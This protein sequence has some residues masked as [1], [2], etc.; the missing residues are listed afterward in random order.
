[1]TAAN[2]VP[3][4]WLGL[5]RS[6][7]AVILGPDT[8][9]PL[10][11]TVWNLL[12]D[13]PEVHDVLHAVTSG[14]GVPLS[15]TPWFGI[16]GF[17]ESLRVFLRGDLDLTVQLPG[18]PVELDGR[19]V[20]TWTER[21]L[22]APEWFSLTVPGQSSA[23]EL[24]VTEGAVLLKSLRVEAA[25]GGSPAVKSRGTRSAQF[26]SPE[27]AV[28]LGPEASAETVAGIP[29]ET[30]AGMPGNGLDGARLEETRLP[31]TGLTVTGA[32][33]PADLP[34]EPDLPGEVEG[35]RVPAPATELTGSYDHLWDKTV[36]R[37]IEDA[38]V[39]ED[40]EDGEDD[41]GAPPA[42]GQETAGNEAAGQES[43]GPEA[44]APAA[45]PAAAEAGQGPASHAPVSGGLID[46]VPWA[47]GGDRAPR[48]QSPPSFISLPD[49]RPG[50]EDPPARE[51]PEQVTHVQELPGQLADGDHDGQTILKN[52][53]SA[54]TAQPAAAP[55]SGQAPGSGPVGGGPLVLARVCGRGHANPPTS[56]QC[57]ACGSALPNVA[58]QVPRPRL[59][60]LR[61]STGELIDLD[62]SLVIG[63]Q[64]S[65]SRVQGGVMPRLVQVPS[66]G[67][68]I[69][70]SHVEVRL[71][72][73]HVMLCDLK[74]TN[75]TVL[76]REGQPP[77]R[78]AQNE[79]AIVLDGD[80]AELGDDVSLRF[81]EIL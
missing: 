74:A 80:I 32:A 35:Q 25:G 77:R 47:T 48:P 20:T 50:V 4:S 41:D 30:S 6:G 37:S 33:D 68:D 57:P 81:E 71:E 3:G 45:E 46:S 67:G 11:N 49:A 40:G 38:A 76:V 75:G 43:A 27:V 53:L 39:R 42:P 56:A 44:A 5:V 70:R 24:P 9:A 28:G 58:V 36:M 79:M 64:P 29:E 63:R 14:F 8:P 72:G 7:T 12:G 13:G 34:D 18:G 31:E 61:L 52:D 51:L 62:E 54:S 10:V 15:R 69:S 78:L 22:D 1:M 66:P 2:Y 65:V 21:W 16:I 19:N 73:W 26:A 17:R 59:G 55:A 60:R 23:L